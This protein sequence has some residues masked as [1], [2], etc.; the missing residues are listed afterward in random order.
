[1]TAEAPLKGQAVQAPSP[2]SVPTTRKFLY[3]FLGLLVVAIVVAVPVTV[4]Q[5]AIH[6][7]NTRGISSGGSKPLSQDYC[8]RLQGD[9]RTYC[10]AYLA[11]KGPS[12][13]LAASVWLQANQTTR[14]SVAF[15]FSDAYS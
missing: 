6:R 4:T 11:A 13:Y 9:S 8:N 12:K 1:M 2:F 7:R 5:F 15:T 3:G 10:N 14:E